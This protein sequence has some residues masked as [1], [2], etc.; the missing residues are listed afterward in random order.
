MYTRLF[1]AHLSG[2]ATRSAGVE[3]CGSSAMRMP[4]TRIGKASSDA[5]ALARIPMAG[6]E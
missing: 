5:G 6:R 1:P 4:P 2:N 3:A